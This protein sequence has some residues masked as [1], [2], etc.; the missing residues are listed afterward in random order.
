M[1]RQ[2][3]DAGYLLV[4][5]R[6]RTGEQIVA[7][8]KTPLSPTLTFHSMGGYPQQSNFGTDL[9]ILNKDLGILDLTLQLAWQLRQAVTISDCVFITALLRFQT[10]IYKQALVKVKIK[11]DNNFKSKEWILQDFSKVVENLNYPQWK[12]QARN[13]L[14]GLPFA[15]RW[16]RS[17]RRQRSLRSGLA[18]SSQSIR[19]AYIEN[20]PSIV[21]QSALSSTN[22]SYNELNSPAS[23]D[24]AVI[25]EWCLDQLFLHSI[26]YHYT[27]S[28]GL[29]VARESIRTFYQTT[30]R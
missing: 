23:P 12:Q 27:V 1:I 18:L 9:I 10:T 30:T 28:N 21:P 14:Q 29:F 4:N 2:R 6:L 16:Q 11:V 13:D 3:I 20:I 19:Q 5:Y 7:F 24:Y 25:L 17:T 22:S 15:L 8:Q 26:P